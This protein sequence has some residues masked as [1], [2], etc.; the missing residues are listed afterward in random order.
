[1]Q[2]LSLLAQVTRA[3]TQSHGTFSTQYFFKQN[4]KSPVIKQKGESQSKCFKKTKH[5]KFS[6]K[7][8]ISYP[9]IRTRT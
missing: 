6:E 9:L 7:R 4:K 5:A 8:N 3:K 2:V 1:M